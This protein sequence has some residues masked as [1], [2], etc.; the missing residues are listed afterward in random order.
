MVG[1]E[2]RDHQIKKTATL[3]RSC[4]PHSRSVIFQNGAAQIFE[5]E[6]M[7]DSEVKKVLSELEL[8]DL[9]ADSHVTMACKCTCDDKHACK[10]FRTRV[11]SFRH[12]GAELQGIMVGRR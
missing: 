12:L 5:Q 10:R 8:F 6:D 9:T 11:K 4:S 1:R 7:P 2:P 3:T